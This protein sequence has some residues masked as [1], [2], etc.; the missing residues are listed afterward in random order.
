MLLLFHYIF[1]HFYSYYLLK[2]QFVCL[3]IILFVE[4]IWVL[5]YYCLCMIK[6]VPFAY[7]ERR[8]VFTAKMFSL[9]PDKAESVKTSSLL[10]LYVTAPVITIAVI[11]LVI[12]GCVKMKNRSRRRDY[13][14]LNP[15]YLS[16]GWYKWPQYKTPPLRNLCGKLWD[17]YILGW[18][19]V[20]MP[21]R[22]LTFDTTPTTGNTNQ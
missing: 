1:I 21:R 14:Q 11:G 16:T 8:G 18:E 20:Y 19:E 3:L 6:M 9:F 13:I 5:F 15:I 10:P 4:A 2:M 17:F 12:F 7:C 22:T